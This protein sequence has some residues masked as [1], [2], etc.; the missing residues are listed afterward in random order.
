MGER[1]GDRGAVTPFETDEWNTHFEENDR[2]LGNNRPIAVKLRDVT[3]GGESL[4]AFLQA[5]AHGPPNRTEFYALLAPCGQDKPP[6]DR[7]D[8]SFF[9]MV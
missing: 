8:S 4:S 5:A 3:T 1:A 7:T 6:F 2:R 9:R